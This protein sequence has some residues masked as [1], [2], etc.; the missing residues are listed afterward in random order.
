MGEFMSSYRRE[1]KTET[2]SKLSADAK[3]N[4]SGNTI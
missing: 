3:S 4:S 1:P 2:Y